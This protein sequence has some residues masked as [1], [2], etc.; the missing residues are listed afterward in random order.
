LTRLREEGIFKWNCQCINQP[1]GGDV[2]DLLIGRAAFIIAAMDG[3]FPLPTLLSHTLVAFTIEFDNEFEHQVPHRTT[4]YGSTAGSRSVPWLVSMVMWLK[5]MRFVPSEGIAVQELQRLARFTD[6]EMHTWLTR[7][8]KW[9]GYVEV[10]PHAADSASKVDP[11]DRVV[12]PTSG[13]QKA[14]ET[15]QPLTRVIEKRWQERF[16]KDV[17]ARL[18]QCL[19]ALVKKFDS[20]LTDYLPILGY[21]LFGNDPN[22]ESPTPAKPDAPLLSEYTLPILLS[23]VLLAFAIEFERNSEVSLAVS[24]NVL[25]LT[26]PEGVRVRDL[27][28]LSGV[29]KEAIAMSVGRLAEG[30]YAVL[31][32]ESP[33]SRIKVLRLTPKGRR[34]KDV[35]HQLVWA[36]EEKWQASFGK[37]A[38]RNLRQSLERLA[39]EPNAQSAPLFRGLEP[40][41]DGWRAAVRRPKTLP[42]YPMV[43][44]R[45]GF[46]D[47]S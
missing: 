28:R 33:G 36:I 6:K 47:G 17:V 31:Q 3:P 40:Y 12:H 43:L 22:R 4:N 35:Y 18:Q 32:P 24:A 20:D 11:L 10:K 2:G 46:P 41:S 45:G 34:A 26:G 1:S 38:I 13:G 42:H 5:F 7:M 39:G 37:D 14:V 21:E 15:W 8:G 19:L 44:H 25:R 23:K 9:W 27:P 30:G 29:S 16:G